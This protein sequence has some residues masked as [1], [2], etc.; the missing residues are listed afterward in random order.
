MRARPEHQRTRL[1]QPRPRRAA[2]PPPRRLRPR[3]RRRRKRRR[4]SPVWTQP[5]RSTPTTGC[6]AWRGCLRCARMTRRR[7][8]R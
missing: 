6:R 3:A 8:W 7:L 2:P 1:S 5:S 4:P